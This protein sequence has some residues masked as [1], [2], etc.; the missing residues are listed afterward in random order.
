M[1]LV[2]S[3]VQIVGTQKPTEGTDLKSPTTLGETK[4]HKSHTVVCLLYTSDAADDALSVEDRQE[5][6]ELYYDFG[7]KYGL[8]C[9]D[10]KDD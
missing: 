8:D 3:M 6:I 4:W 2:K 10:A 9:R 5:I 7:E 1:S